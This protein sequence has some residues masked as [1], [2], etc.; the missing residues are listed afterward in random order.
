MT[1]SELMAHAG[2]TEGWTLHD[3]ERFRLLL[4]PQWQAERLLDP[5]VMLM[6]V[7]SDRAAKIHI[8]AHPHPASE[9]LSQDTLDADVRADPPGEAE[10]TKRA[11]GK[12]VAQAVVDVQGHPVAMA[13]FDAKMPGLLGQKRVRQAC[14]LVLRPGTVWQLVVM[15]TGRDARMAEAHFTE[16]ASDLAG[17]ISSFAPI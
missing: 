3:R 1:P 11:A 17:M 10:W 14:V 6:A 4:P 2:P 13:I 7:S 9:G 5:K 15:G 16:H 12:L 8:I